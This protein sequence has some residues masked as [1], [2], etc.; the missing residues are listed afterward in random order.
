MDFRTD[1]MTYWK[2]GFPGL[3]V[4]SSEEPRVEEILLGAVKE[5]AAEP[6]V[7]K[8]G[9]K[10]RLYIW[11]LTRG[12]VDGTA[13]GLPEV[14]VSGFSG[15]A[16]DPE[17]GALEMAERFPPRTIALFKDYHHWMDFPN[18]M[19]RIRDLAELYK[20]SKRRMAVFCA[21][22]LPYQR[23][24]GVGLPPEIANDLTLVDL[25]LPTREELGR[26]LDA[27]VTAPQN[28][29]TPPLADERDKLLEAAT[30][31]TTAQAENAFALAWL[32]NKAF[33]A[34]AVQT[35]YECKTAAVKKSGS[36]ECLLQS[37]ESLDDV[38]GFNLY[39]SFVERKVATFTKTA[40]EFGLRRSKGVLL[41][42]APG[43][44]KSLCAKATATALKLPLL[45]ADIGALYG[46]FVGDS[47]RN[48][49]EMIKMAE[50]MSP[51]VLWIDEID[52]TMGSATAAGLTSD[53]TQRVI[54][55]ILTWRQESTAPVFV[56][57]TA[58][59]LDK[60]D[61]ALMRPGRFDAVFWVDLP[62]EEERAY[63]FKIHLR[64]K[65]RDKLAW[66]PPKALIAMAKR[67]EGY[68][69]AEIAEAVEE[70]LLEAF[71]RSGSD[72]ELAIRDIMMALERS[73]PLS[74]TAEKELS[75]MREWLKGKCRP[76]ASEGLLFEPPAAGQSRRTVG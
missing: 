7:K 3:Y 41:L 27:L 43:T 15:N 70:G 63:I 67:A 60:L 21:P 51:V 24:A 20:G 55:T 22:R 49:R 2:A 9:D 28:A 57:A 5:M 30:G 19:R 66:V 36:L 61:P 37:G 33:G 10:P 72:R 74:E 16:K 26:V 35:V 45:R 6:A 13:P 18:V 29:I 68:S 53:V 75:M 11:T 58:N 4:V 50:A 69:G 17:G 48:T 40:R 34:G 64:K 46:S 32:V 23:D 71:H 54:G 14:K 42:G 25:P 1:V 73:K 56:V 44:G 47:E 39:K 52:K 38:G 12:W 65:Q 31:M 62:G 76:V 8:D 59:R